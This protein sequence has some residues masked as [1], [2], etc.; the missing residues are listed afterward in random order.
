M[1]I[2]TLRR[3]EETKS[4]MTI[5]GFEVKNKTLIIGGVILAVLI[6]GSKLKSY[7]EEKA[8]KA[9]LEE[10]R[11]AAEEEKAR[12][13]AA[14]AN[15]TSPE[16]LSLHEQ[17]QAELRK[18]Y[19]DPPEGFEWS[20]RG[21]LVAISS[22]DASCEDVVFMFLRSLSMQ[23][24]YT[25]GMYSD[26]SVIIESLEKAHG[27]VSKGRT[28]YYKS[29]LNKQLAVAI[30]SL[31]IEQISNVM[32]FPDGTQYVTV[33]I[34]SLD[35]STKDFIDEHSEEL[36]K[37]MRSYSEVEKD[38]SKMNNFVYDWLY[39]QYKDGVVGKK[40]YTVELV[41]EKVNQGGW[42]VSNDR[43]LYAVLSYENG[44]NTADYIM[45]QYEVWLREVERQERRNGVG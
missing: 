35:L 31:E 33:D 22:D 16:Q 28:S 36:F 27:E 11:R 43:E 21:E 30:S 24:F 4:S 18:E 34:K 38:K 37:S 19:G 3:K 23:D 9:Q 1:R 13:E 5:G 6:G 44:L 29:F 26:E 41:V 17:R 14:L 25:A 10:D 15:Q 39:E 2:L 8:W 32:V 12:R 45:K 20:N 40:D 42:L 7:Q